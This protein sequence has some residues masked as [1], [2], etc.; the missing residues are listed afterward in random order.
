MGVV[1]KNEMHP[2]GMDEAG[3]VGQCLKMEL[4]VRGQ[5]ESER[6]VQRD[7]GRRW[8]AWGLVYRGIS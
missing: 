8:G 1:G 3:H 7:A 6:R 2:K 4:G 5:L